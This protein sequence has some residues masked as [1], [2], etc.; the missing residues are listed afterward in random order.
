MVTITKKTKKGRS[1]SNL[2]ALVNQN[3]QNIQNNNLKKCNKIIQSQ[4]KILAIKFNEKRYN[5]TYHKLQY[6]IKSGSK[7]FNK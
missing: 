3:W 6:I 4:A 5:Q 7:I 2:T 1:K